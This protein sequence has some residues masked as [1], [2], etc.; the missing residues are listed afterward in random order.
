MEV[1]LELPPVA[2]V[3]L[4]V[5]RAAEILAKRLGIGSEGRDAIGIALAEACLN[6][7]EHGAGGGGIMVRLVARKHGDGPGELLAEI[8][9]HGPG[10]QASRLTASPR[11]GRV[12]KRGWGLVLIRELM[13]EVEIESHPGRTV[14][15]MRKFAEAG[16]DR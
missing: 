15:R 5:V 14:V 11:G 8:E 7:L 3:E 4:V 1:R 16:N 2:D 13:D 10:F 12:R 6:A 9:D